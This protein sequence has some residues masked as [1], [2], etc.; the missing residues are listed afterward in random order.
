MT[1][2]EPRLSRQGYDWTKATIRQTGVYHLERKDQ[3]YTLWLCLHPRENSRSQQQ[4]D[5]ALYSS[6]QC[7]ELHV[8]SLFVHLLFL[9]SY[10][11]NWRWYLNA[12]TER[13]ERLVRRELIESSHSC[14]PI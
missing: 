9:A 14:I 2:P 10:V 1:Y 6:E 8:N 7:D 3:D 5:K 11:E 12:L 4:L 13:F